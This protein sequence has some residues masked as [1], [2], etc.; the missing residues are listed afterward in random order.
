MASRSYRA[1]KVWEAVPVWEAGGSPVLVVV[2]AV[3]HKVACLG[4]ELGVAP[5]WSSSAS[6]REYSSPWP[7][8]AP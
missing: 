6:Q 1:A 7:T 4:D 3:G 8:A 2:W 5:D